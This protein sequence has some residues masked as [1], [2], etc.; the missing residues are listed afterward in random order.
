MRATT[1]SLSKEDLARVLDRIGQG[2]GGQGGE[3][4]PAP[5]VA[6]SSTRRAAASSLPVAASST[7]SSST[8]A[9]RPATPAGQASAIQTLAAIYARNRKRS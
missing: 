2:G 9:S 4:D 1:G 8:G 7:S 6:A 3:T 5:V